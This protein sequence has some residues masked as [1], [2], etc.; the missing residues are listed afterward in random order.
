MTPTDERSSLGSI[1]DQRPACTAIVCAYNE[2]TTL[3]KVLDALLP[4]ARIDE[5]IVLDDGSRDATPDI[6]QQYAR[7]DKVNGICFGRNRGKGYAMAEA[8]VRARG[9]VLLYV[10]ADLLNWSEAY[11]VQVLQPLLSNEAEMVIGYPRRDRADPDRLTPWLHWLSGQRAVWRHDLLPLV[12]TLRESRYGVETLINLYY[13]RR[14]KRITLLPLHGLIHPA[15]LEKEPL[16]RAVQA[17]A[18]EGYQIAQAVA[19]HY[20][21]AMAA[22]GVKPPMTQDTLTHV[23]VR[24]QLEEMIR[25]TRHKLL[26]TGETVE[27]VMRLQ[28]ELIPD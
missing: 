7:F 24:D 13:R 10:D 25:W 23:E 27:R 1:P 2:A 14:C 20:P 8:A 5:L 22:Y 26:T 6:V 9:D 19:G 11:A 16:P 18:R 21:L 3:G 12:D 15:K 4:S 17:Y 28:E